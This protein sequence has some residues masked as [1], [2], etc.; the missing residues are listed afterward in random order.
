MN[1]KLLAEYL[2]Y[3]KSWGRNQILKLS[4]DFDVATLHK[5]S[6]LFV[7]PNENLGTVLL[8]LSRLDVTKSQRLI[9]VCDSEFQSYD[10]NLT[11]DFVIQIMVDVGI[12]ADVIKDMSMVLRATNSKRH[13]REKLMKCYF[14]INCYWS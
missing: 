7:N 10:Q 6:S 4:K 14:K 5:L 2:S 3:N 8:Y 9:D 11:K 1:N 13:L 12:D